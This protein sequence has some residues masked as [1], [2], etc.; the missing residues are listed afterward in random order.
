MTCIVGIVEGDKV[1]IGGDSISAAGWSLMD[2]AD[3]KV[4]RNGP[5]VFGFTTS[6]RMGQLLQYAFN[7]PKRH[8]EQDVMAFMVTDFI[9]TVRAC[10][11]DGGYAKKDSEVESGGTFLVGYEGRLFKVSDDY[12][13]GETTDGYTACGCGESFAL[14]ALYATEG[15]PAADRI[16]IALLAAEKNSGGVRGPFLTVST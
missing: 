1:L 13:V 14:G 12:Q 5:F 11:K 2:R 8:V 3:K 16:N 4:F 6:Y 10:L 7:P 15:E 9:A